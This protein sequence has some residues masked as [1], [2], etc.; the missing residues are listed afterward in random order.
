[1]DMERAYKSADFVIIA[2]PNNYDS[3]ENFFDTSAADAVTNKVI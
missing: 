2:V 3:K 1:M